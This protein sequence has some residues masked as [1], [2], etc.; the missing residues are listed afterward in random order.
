MKN[1][2]FPCVI[3]RTKETELL[4]GDEFIRLSE[5]KNIPDILKTIKNNGY[6]ESEEIVNPRDFER[7]LK[8]NMEE[9]YELIYSV[10]PEE[11]ELDFFKF[12]SDYHNLKAILKA[13]FSE[14]DPSEL[15]V[16]SGTV[17]PEELIDY[18]RKREMNMLPL[19]MGEAVLEAIELFGK[20]GDPQEIDIRLD[21]ACY[22]EMLESA[23]ASG[24]DFLLEYAKN[25]VDLINISTFVRLME[26]GRPK[27]F[28][29]R[30]FIEGGNIMQA[31]IEPIAMDIIGKVTVSGLEK[32]IDNQK[33]EYVKEAFYIPFGF[34]PIIGFI[35]AKETEWKNLR[36]IMAGKMAGMPDV[37][38]RERLRDTY[39]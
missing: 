16:R 39:V 5:Q 32:Y 34:E 2:I 12:P 19:E 14:Q 38:I 10:I 29:E 24:S 20:S 23:E 17:E 7:I 37:E 4:T 13:E 1:Y 25:T 36:I 8:Q 27:T 21:R 33:M 35:Q 31:D 15:L 18:V 6:G 9:T 28:Y 26:T 3:I 11:N 30:V 22:K